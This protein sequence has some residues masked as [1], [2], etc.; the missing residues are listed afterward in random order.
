MTRELKPCGTRAAYL[1]HLKNREPPCFGCSYA[2]ATFQERQRA[3]RKQ[4]ERIRQRHERAH[5]LLRRFQL[6]QDIFQ[7]VHVLAGALDARRA[8]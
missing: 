6:E 3:E 4:R 1:R 2:N 8:A 5:V 7:L